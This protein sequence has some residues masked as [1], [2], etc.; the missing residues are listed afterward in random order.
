MSP[1]ISFVSSPLPA[2]EALGYEGTF[3]LR[4]AET[5][6]LASRIDRRTIAG[7]WDNNAADGDHE[8]SYNGIQNLYSV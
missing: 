7:H 4:A 2:I 1:R 3:P 8:A 6:A 5:P